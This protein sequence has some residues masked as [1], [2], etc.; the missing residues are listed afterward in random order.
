MT[1]PFVFRGVMKRIAL[2][3]SYDGSQFLGWQTQ[4][5][6]QTVQD[7]LQLALAKIVGQDTPVATVCAGRTDTGVHA[8]AQVVHFDVAQKRPLSAWV[9]GV[10]SHLPE[11]IAV[12]Q[13]FEV[14]D[15]F[16]ARRSALARTY[17]YVILQSVSRQ[18]LWHQKAGWVFRPLSL[19]AMQEA[20]QAFIGTHD[21]SS[22]RSSQC[23]A[24]SPIRTIKTCSVRACGPLVIVTVTANAFLHHMI[25]N[26][27]GVLVEIGVGRRQPIWANQV[28]VQRDR[29]RAAPTFSASGLYLSDVQYPAHFAIQA[30]TSS[31]IG[32]PWEHNSVL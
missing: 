22:L 25:R 17:D 21:F 19:V 13:A 16:D 12:H 15:D 6:R 1:V 29:R 2:S 23:Q 27:V 11:G 9:R 14:V 31:A 32:L 18:P 4:P 8:L 24:R 28:L 7:H 26:L 20:A 30:R 5:N 3:L 10:N